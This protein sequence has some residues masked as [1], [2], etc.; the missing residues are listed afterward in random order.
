MKNLRFKNQHPFQKPF[1]HLLLIPIAVSFFLGTPYAPLQI[2]RANAGLFTSTPEQKRANEAAARIKAQQ[3]AQKAHQKELTQLHSKITSKDRIAAGAHDKAVALQDAR[4]EEIRAREAADAAHKEFAQAYKSGTQSEQ[5]DALRGLI[6]AN[7]KVKQAKG[8]TNQKASAARFA[9]VQAMGQEAG[10][11]IK[12]SVGS[13]AKM[14]ATKGG[15]EALVGAAKG[16]AVAS[17]ASMGLGAKAVAVI[18]TAAVTAHPVGVFVAAGAVV[19]TASATSIAVVKG[20]LTGAHRGYQNT[21]EARRELA[22]T[23]KRQKIIDKR[24]LAAAKEWEENGEG[25][26][27]R[28]ANDKITKTEKEKR[29]KD[30]LENIDK[31]LDQHLDEMRVGNKSRIKRFYLGVREHLWDT[32]KSAVVGIGNGIGKGSRYL[33]SKISGKP[34]KPAESVTKVADKA[35]F[36]TKIDKRAKVLDQVQAS[37]REAAAALDEAKANGRPTTELENN[38]RL[39]KLMTQR[40]KISVAQV[41]M[42]QVSYVFKVNPDDPKAMSTAHQR[43]KDTKEDLDNLKAQYENDKGEYY[44]YSTDQTSNEQD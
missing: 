19:G 1:Q 28:A 34:S 44:R 8:K 26:E 38:H 35:N 16:H 6:D 30:T 22:Y 23:Q 37:E 42:D 43:V 18:G 40:A 14:G 15:G 21:A 32:P 10:T 36:E 24:G 4:T 31:S 9:T 17:A 2:N 3:K 39:A 7:T 41:K 29:K 13:L 33:T 25:K 11:D 27:I 12:A 5:A 20:T